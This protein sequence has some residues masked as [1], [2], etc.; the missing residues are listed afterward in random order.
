MP[1]RRLGL[2]FLGCPDI[3]AMAELGRR[4][5][6]AGF[7]SAW[8]SETRIT[9]DAVTGITALLLATERLRV[10]SAAINVF[11]RGAALTAVTWASLAEAA[12]NRVVLGLGAGSLTPLV[13]QGYVVDYP[14][15]RLREYV[16][17]VRA[18]WSAPLPVTYS[19]RFTRFADLQPEVR[20]PVPLPIYFCVAGPRALACAASMADG[21][22]LDAFMPPQY[23]RMTC[24]RLA[25]AA[26]G[27]Y[28][29]EVAGAIVVSLAP[30][31]SEG[32]ARVRPLL[33]NY[34]VHFP[35]LAR[36]TGLDPDFIAYLRRRAAS[37]G[38]TATYADLADDLVARYAACGPPESCRER[39]AEYRAAG[40]QLPIVFPEPRSMAGAITALAGA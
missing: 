40:L 37:D 20:P 39:L 32:A 34:L 18:A 28:A 26:G 33:A 8:V 2:G 25:E 17:A 24:A 13:Q 31:V 1:E 9:R 11:T 6:A 4:A 36:E 27:R 29:G 21:V 19:G 15:S 3:R 12:P 23:A 5:E 7:E 14:L 10:G 35:E 22:V 16:E 30:S 38:V